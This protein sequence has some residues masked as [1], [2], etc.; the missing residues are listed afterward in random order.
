MI[1]SAP[2]LFLLTAMLLVSA[3]GCEPVAEPSSSPTGTAPMPAEQ[4]EI[5]QVFSA[6]HTGFATAEQLVILDRATLDRTLERARRDAL[7]EDTPVQVDFAREM[8][9]LVAA[10]HQSTGGHGITIDEVSREANGARVQFTVIRPGPGCMTT[11]VLTS[12][13]AAAAVPRVEGEVTFVRR[14]QVQPC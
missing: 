14:E 5:R 8:V 1:P 4:L 9:V 11:Q 3:R 10:G 12:P 2:T 13:A 6:T 7:V